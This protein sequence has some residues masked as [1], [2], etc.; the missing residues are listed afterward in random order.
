MNM[1]RYLLVASLFILTLLSPQLAQ[2]EVRVVATLGDLG[3][4]A[5]EVGGPHVEVTTLAAP[6]EDPHFVDA[7]PSYVG[8]VARADLLIVNGMSLEIGW[9]PTLLDNSRNGAVQQ[10]QPGYFDAS[11]VVERK[12]VPETEISRSM[13]DV[14][15]EGNPHYTVDPRQM[16][17]VALALGKRLGEIDPKHAED[18]KKRA[19]SFARECLKVAKKWS[20]KFEGLEQAQRRVVVY[21]EA[22]IYVLDWLGLERAIAVEPKPGVEPNPRQVRKVIDTIAG[23]DIEVILKMEYYPSATAARIAEKTGS[24][25]VTSQGQARSEQNYI[26]RVDRL[27]ESIYQKIK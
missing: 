15:P 22:W 3:A 20:N 27:A 17:R 12:E 23:R 24:S 19:R 18:Y 14:H 6:Q 21:H 9:L 13:G 8:E 26:D 11:T 25:V 7:K 2:G 4:A 1:H 5:R 16:A 10:G